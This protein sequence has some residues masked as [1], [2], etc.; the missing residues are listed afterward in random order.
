MLR[1]AIY[2]VEPKPPST[3][4]ASA[5]WGPSAAS[6][7]VRGLTAQ[8]IFQPIAGAAGITA[9]ASAKIS[10][11]RT[12]CAIECEVKSFQ[13]N[14]EPAG[15]K[16]HSSPNLICKGDFLSTSREGNHANQNHAGFD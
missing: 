6:N 5:Y 7:Q 4:G 16:H 10:L 1:G 3:D 11:L 9:V 12:Q 15:N 13:C 8:R 2:S 14:V